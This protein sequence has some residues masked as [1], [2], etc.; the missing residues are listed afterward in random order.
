MTLDKYNGVNNIC[1]FEQCTVMGRIGNCN[2]EM[3]RNKSLSCFVFLIKGFTL[4]LALERRCMCV[5]NSCSI[6]VTCLWVIVFSQMWYMRLGSVLEW[7]FLHM[8]KSYCHTVFVK[9]SL[10]SRRLRIIHWHCAK[11]TS[12]NH[13]QVWECVSGT[14]SHIPWELK[15]ARC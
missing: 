3:C 10:A 4:N 7:A 11:D 14:H 2:S 6:T 1:T 9:L 12:H 8:I 13:K 5:L 15:L